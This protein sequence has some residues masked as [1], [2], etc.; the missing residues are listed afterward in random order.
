[1]GEKID[2]QHAVN[3]GTMV[4]GLGMQGAPKRNSSPS[5]HDFGVYG[6]SCQCLGGLGTGVPRFN[7]HQISPSQQ[8]PQNSMDM[9]SL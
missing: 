4:R 2:S 6:Y 1:M 9:D 5:N 8:F 3:S 7:W